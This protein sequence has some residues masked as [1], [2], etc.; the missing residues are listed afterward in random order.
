MAETG[1][2]GGVHQTLPHDSAA[3]HVSGEAIYIDDIP[4]PPGLLHAAFGIS[5]KPHARIRSIDLAPVRAAPGVV[6]VIAA[7]DVPGAN[8]VGPVIADEPVFAEDL[9]QYAGQS[10]FAVAAETVEQARRAAR[11]AVIDYEELPAVLTVE[12]ALQQD[13]TVLPPHVM[14][15]GQSRP[16]IERAA[17]RLSGRIKIG[18]QDHFYLEG[19]VSM[20]LPL[21]DG[22]LL[23][24]CSTQHPSEV[25]HTIAHALGCRNSDITVEVRRMGGGFGGKETQAAIFAVIAS[26]LAR[27][28]GRPVKARADRDDDMIMTG[29]RHD[30]V[31]DY[32]VGFDDAGRIQGIEFVQAA[33]CGLSADLSGAIADRAMFHADNCYYLENVTIT[34]HRCKTHT[35][36]NTA[37]RGFGG[38]QGMVGIE[39]VVDEIARHL[40]QDPLAV[41]KANFYGTEERNVTPYHMTVTDN[42]IGELIAD[43][44]QSADYAARRR[45]IEAFNAASPVFKK[46][47]ALTPVKFGIS[48]T[49]S[50]LNQAGALVHVY[51]DGSVQLNHGG[52]EM[53]QGLFVKVA[54]IVAEVFQID[55]DRVKITATSTGK[56]PNTSATAASSGTDLNGAAAQ[57]AAGKIRDRLVAFAAEQYQVAPEAVVFE[58]NQVRV[59]GERMSFAELVKAAYLGRVQLSATG[60]FRTPGIHYDRETARGRPFRYFAYGAAVSEVAIDSLTGEYKLLRA[61]IL[62]DCGKSLNPA[63]DLGQVE[64]GFVQGMGWLTMEELVWNPDGQLATHAPSTYKIPTSGDLP[65]DFR[66]RLLESGRNREEVVHRSKAVGEPPLMLAISVF[67]A[68]K[69]AVAAVC[70]HKLSPRLDAP[71]TPE[72]ILMTIEDMKARLGRARKAAE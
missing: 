28:T 6:A 51:T 13:L 22:D 41:R 42:I 62:H 39:Q 49:T 52:T 2:R 8:N 63:I 40:G 66:V 27:K 45:E 32:E 14:Q 26:L 5:D 34:S 35:V 67:M 72:R 65:A 29:K 21:E 25:Q 33:R 4:E 59:G 44:E 54:Q 61:D 53:G 20:A 3:K 19:Q 58:N 46:G 12:E 31:I 60:F 11:L 15:R 47:L 43:L 36:S 30:F 9:V 64:G 18:G 56:V 1:I 16:A 69:D 50:F 55:L 7:G 68:L 10:I 38:P 70:D 48:F 17:N 23:V 71:A 24:H 57:I 37:F